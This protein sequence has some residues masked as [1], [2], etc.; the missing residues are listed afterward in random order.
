MSVAVVTGAGGLVGSEAV[1][2][3]IGQGLEVVGI[4]NDMRGTFF[5]PSASTLW[6]TTD[7]QR[8][9]QRYRHE[10]IDVRDG[11]RLETLFLEFGSAISAVVHAAAQPSHDWAASNPTEDFTINAVGTLNLLEA[12]RR[13]AAGSAFVFLSTNKVYGDTPNR[14]PLIEGATRWELDPMHAYAAAGIDET[15]TIDHSMHSLF[16]VSK[17]SADLMV[18]EYGRYF[19]MRTTCLRAGCLTGGEHAAA[20]QHGFLAYLMKC[21]ATGRAY[22]VYGHNGKQVRDILHARDLILAIWHVI[23]KPGC[24]SVYNVGGGRRSNCSLLEAIDACER[25]V[26][27]ELVRSYSDC[28]R[29]GDHIWWISD[30]FAFARA[31]PN[32]AP[33]VDLEATLADIYDKGR[34]RWAA[35][36]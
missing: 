17:A 2:F 18:Q 3:L 10:T 22:T 32:Y 35:G 11:G 14:L 23:E 4:D 7:L 1:E 13:H 15:M 16:G 27:R 5:G 31:H 20:E 30:M 19:G 12:T 34:R 33:S 36:A 8:R 29:A 24:G 6:R 21:V 28:A 25:V 9:H 26:G